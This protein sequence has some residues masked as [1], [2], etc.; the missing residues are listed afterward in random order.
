MADY[1]TPRHEAGNMIGLS[2]T[3]LSNLEEFVRLSQS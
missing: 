1:N 2:M 3:E